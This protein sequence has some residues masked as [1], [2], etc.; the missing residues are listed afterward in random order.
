MVIEKFAIIENLAMVRMQHCCEVRAK[1]QPSYFRTVTDLWFPLV[2][3][4][5]VELCLA[6]FF[7]FMQMHLCFG[8][9]V[10]YATLTRLGRDYFQW[11]LSL[12]FTHF[13]SLFVFLSVCRERVA[14]WS[15]ERCY[16]FDTFSLGKINLL[17]ATCTGSM[18]EC[19]RKIVE[20]SK[21]LFRNQRAW[22]C[23]S[24][25]EWMELLSW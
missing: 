16:R 23:S 8:G 24:W 7:A 22:N 11:R 9:A 1:M 13:L 20:K 12:S 18:C 21:L 25:D 4:E 15:E 6:C 3:G 2:C 14:L 5:T 17:P 10:N 19:I